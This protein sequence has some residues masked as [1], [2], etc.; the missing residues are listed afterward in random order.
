MPRFDV[1]FEEDVVATAM[2]DAAYR[3]QAARICEEGHFSTKELSWLWRR[4]AA[5]P[6]GEACTGK[7]LAAYI[8]ADFTDPD[9]ARQ[10]LALVRK[11]LAKKTPHARASLEQ[12]RKFITHNTLS[13]GIEVA[14]KRLDSGD[15]DA[16]EEALYAA[17]RN[18]TGTEYV[19]G[20]WI[21]EMESRMAARK[22]RAEDPE[23]SIKVT[24][25]LD[26]LDKLLNGGLKPGDL[27]IVAGL[28]GIGKS[29]AAI[30]GAMSAAAHG[31]NTLLVDTENGLETEF[32]RLDARF[33]GAASDKVYSYEL[34]VSELSRMTE[35]LAR[36]KARLARKLKVIHISPRNAT[37]R[38]LEQALDDMIREGRPCQML[39][40]DCA[41]HLQPAKTNREYRLEQANVFWDIKSIADEYGIPIAV[42]SQLSKEAL[43]RIATAE[44][45]SEAYDKSRIASVVVTLNQTRKEAADGRMR[46]FL[47]KQRAGKGKILIPVKCD[48]SRSH[49]EYD[50]EADKEVEEKDD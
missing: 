48:L 32:D 37:T 33:I 27:M 45:M 47:A 15:V 20:E 21:E 9:K 28:T 34:S 25:G 18:K 1:E 40:V 19:A 35:K 13:A 2:Q 46:W 3:Q 22:K 4:V 38:L 14:I 39:W 29:H 5:L 16:A 17:S 8:K 7:L 23:A 41:D 42:T 30:A 44:H 24:T 6:P 11:L 50:E 12:L 26:R 31:F 36:Q 43:N 49:F 10:A